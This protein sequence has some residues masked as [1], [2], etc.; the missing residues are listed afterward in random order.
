MT[1]SNVVAR[2]HSFEACESLRLGAGMLTLG[3]GMLTLGADMLRLGAD[4]VCIAVRAT[5]GKSWT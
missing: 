3:A 2:D 5:P 4:I 1:L